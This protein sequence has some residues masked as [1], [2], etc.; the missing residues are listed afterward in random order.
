MAAPLIENLND[1]EPC[2]MRRDRQ[3][4]SCEFVLLSWFLCD[5]P[6]PE[7]EAMKL[8]NLAVACQLCDIQ[9]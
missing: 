3:H 1:I 9:R 6:M 4:K 8:A 5:L 2:P 7:P